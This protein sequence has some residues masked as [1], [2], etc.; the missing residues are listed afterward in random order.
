MSTTYTPDAGNNPATITLP[1]DLDAKTAESVNAAFRA[2]ADRG[3]FLNAATA[4]LAGGNTFTANQTVVPPTE[5]DTVLYC[6]RVPGTTPSGNNWTP[7]FRFNIE[8][9]YSLRF[10]V[11][12]ENGVGRWAW[13]INAIWNVDDQMWELE[14]DSATA[15]ALVWRSADFSVYYVD[16]EADPFASWASL[17]SVGS[18][19]AVRALGEFRYVQPKAR[20]RTLPVSTASG[21]GVGFSGAT[22][23]VAPST[24]D[25]HSYIR[26]PIRLP[27]GAVLTKVNVL[28]VIDASATETFAVTRRRCTWDAFDPVIPSEDVLASS[29]SD[30]AE[31]THI[32]SV[33][34]S[35]AVD[36]YDELCLR[37]T[38]SA[39]LFNDVYAI[40]IEF[41]DPGPTVL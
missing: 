37:W 36:K 1:S 25:D 23:S 35:A 11:G 41:T 7:V 5:S 15:A 31:G 33:T 28:H 40:T 24:L 39:L 21:L 20:V 14:K 38:P 34:L 13:V 26:F 18:T 8:S 6:S 9:D 30:S 29:V 10:Y 19:A 16:A 32:T 12:S 17:P 4:K 22:G 2:L 3:A 27:P